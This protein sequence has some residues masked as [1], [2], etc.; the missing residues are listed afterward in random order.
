[1]KPFLMMAGGLSLFLT[2][3]AAR[4]DVWDEGPD[5][6]NACGLT[7]DNELVHGSDQIHDLGARPGPAADEDHYTLVSRAYSSYEAILD[8]T[9]GD[10][11]NGGAPDFDFDRNVDGVC[12]PIQDFEPASGWGFSRSIRW[13]SGPSSAAGGLRVANAACGTGCTAA[14]QYRIRLLETTYTIPRFNNSS[15][16]TTILIV[17]NPTHYTIHV[18]SWFFSGN[19]TLLTSAAFTLAPRSAHVLNT[20]SLVQLQGQ[21]GTI[22]LSNDGHYGDLSG[23]AVALEA[24]TGFTFD[25]P[26]TARPH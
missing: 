7:S 21:S 24:A 9:T 3:A 5:S 1:M 6:D 8:G 22:I 14:D 10:L 11:N 26:M 13:E 18:T 19:G 17:Q 25:T 4:A 2:G 20:S 16:Q 15:S 12:T 23:K